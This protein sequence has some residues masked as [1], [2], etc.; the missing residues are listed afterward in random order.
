MILHHGLLNVTVDGIL[1]GAHEVSVEV[2]DQLFLDVGPVD[3]GI[4]V[5]RLELDLGF[6]DVDSGA[7]SV[8]DQV[9]V[10]S[11]HDGF[12]G[13][14]GPTVVTL[15]IGRR[16]D[17]VELSGQA[18][19]A[20]FEFGE[21]AVVGLD[22]LHERNLGQVVLGVVEIEVFQLETESVGQITCAR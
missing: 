17:D 9:Q 1:E 10:A 20:E 5:G 13:V 21:A 22:H 16:H 19:Q 12:G 8:F 11:H 15:A 7:D 2:G 3:S 14:R 6:C 18:Q 4:G